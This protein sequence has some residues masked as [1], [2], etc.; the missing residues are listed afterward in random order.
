MSQYK[1]FRELNLK[2]SAYGNYETGISYPEYK[3]LKVL[4]NYYDLSISELLSDG[5]TVVMDE[6]FENIKEYF[7]KTYREIPS[8]RMIKSILSNIVK[9]M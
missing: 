9:D 6:L 4:A 3:I 1:L 7:Y 2:R 8:N 5:F